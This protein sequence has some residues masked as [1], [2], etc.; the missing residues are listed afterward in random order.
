VVEGW[1]E[2][3]REKIPNLVIVPN[4]LFSHL[5]F[6]TCLLVIACIMHLLFP[7]F[8]FLWVRVRE[9]MHRLEGGRMEDGFRWPVA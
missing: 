1:G 3:G 7:H 2:D 8:L 9:R 6:S 4:L 5:V